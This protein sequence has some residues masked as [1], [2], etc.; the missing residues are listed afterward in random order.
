MMIS[1]LMMVIGVMAMAPSPRLVEGAS[2]FWAVGT[3]L[4]RTFAP[5][6][7]VEADPEM[8]ALLDKLT[9]H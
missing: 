6:E 1:S 4:R 5:A 9:I 7:V 8:R 3:V 2:V